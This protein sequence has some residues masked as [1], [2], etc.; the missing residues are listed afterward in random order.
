MPR[1]QQNE[2]SALTLLALV[3]LKPGDKIWA[4]AHDA[5]TLRIRDVLDFCRNVFNKLYA[6]NTRETFRR[7]TMHQ[8]IDAGI[9]LYNPDDP[10]RAINSPH[11]CYRVAPEALQVIQAYGTAQWAAKLEVFLLSKATL[12][13]RN[14]SARDQF[15]VP[16][17]ISDDQAITLS[18][19]EHSQLIKAIVEDF[20]ERFVPGADLIYVGDTGE[21]WGYFNEPLLEQLGVKV[22]SH[23]KMPDA[24]LYYPERKWLVL[25]EAVTSHGPVDPKRHRELATLFADATA[26]LVYVTAF[27]SRQVMRSYLPEIAWE[28]EVWCADAPSHLIHF[29]GERFLGPYA[30]KP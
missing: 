20:A 29:N 6:E 2:R 22:G 13:Q 28:T 21:K 25:A 7:Q 18:P 26:G 11:N 30:S 17:K 4:K 12:A 1:G 5:G 10:G 27:P 23:G 24:V 8:L 19:G 3:N 15:K 9:A 16:V 14:A